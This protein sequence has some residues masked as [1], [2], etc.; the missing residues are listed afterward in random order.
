MKARLDLGWCLY[1]SGCVPLRAG[2]TSCSS[3][4]AL[5]YDLHEP[6]GVACCPCGRDGREGGTCRV[7]CVEWSLCCGLAPG[8]GMKSQGSPLHCHGS[9]DFGPRGVES[10]TV[11][12]R[13]AFLS[14]SAVLWFKLCFFGAFL[15]ALGGDCYFFRPRVDPFLLIFQLLGWVVRVCVC[16]LMISILRDRLF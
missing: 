13:K 2:T 9:G 12:R 4:C 3:S 10:S 8:P 7:L 6:G 14:F 1:G 5:A 16:V 11:R 15:A